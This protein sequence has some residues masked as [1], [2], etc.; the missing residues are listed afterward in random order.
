[1]RTRVRTRIGLARVAAVAAICL[2]AIAQNACVGDRTRETVGISTLNLVLTGVVEDAASQ[3][4]NLP[5]GEQPNAA[6]KLAAFEV[7][8]ASKKRAL[9]ISDAMP[10]WPDVREMAEAGIASREEFGLIGPGVSTSKRER[11]DRFGEL[12]E[13]T[14]APQ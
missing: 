7:A 12:L 4:P 13:R 9:I 3:I 14:A 8:I 2:I 10:R 6:G 5:P 11:L 1:M